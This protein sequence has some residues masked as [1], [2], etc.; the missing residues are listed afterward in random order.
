MDPALAETTLGRFAREQLAVRLSRLEEQWLRCSQCSSA[1]AIHDVRVSIRRFGEPLRVLK[2]I[3]PKQGRKQVLAELRQVMKL[4][5]R[6]RDID[7]VRD[8]FLHAD[9]PLSPEL[10]L[11]LLNERA[12]VEAGLRAAI[13]VGLA[14]QFAA[15]WRQALVLAH[16]PAAIPNED[17]YSVLPEDRGLVWR[18]NARLV[19]NARSVL[20]ILLAEYSA[21]GDG[22]RTRRIGN[23]RLHALRLSGKH[24]RYVL[25]L[26]RPVY[27]RCMDELLSTLKETQSQL[28]DVTDAAATVAWLRKHGLDKTP[29]AYQLKLFLDLR[30]DKLSGKFADYWND[31]WGL[32]AFHDRWISYLRRYAGKMPP[33]RIYASRTVSA[34]PISE[35]S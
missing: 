22:L 34:E 8:C 18:G 14:T 30:G 5:G 27:G 16:A 6:T 17:T 1:S 11:F 25:E 35:A 23:K 7:I 15:R 24:L 29:E 9:I 26:F 31:H 21:Q 20:P 33:G 28:G 32:P 19:L 13:S 4:A 12:V 3:F 2:R 10:S